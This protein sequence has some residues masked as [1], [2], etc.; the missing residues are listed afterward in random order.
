MESRIFDGSV[1]AV[2]TDGSRSETFSAG[3]RV[4]NVRRIG[5][6]VMFEPVNTYRIAGT[7]AM[8]WSQFETMTTAVREAKVQHLRTK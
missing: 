8:D 1:T 6:R 4:K 7:Y 2:S 5:K 3:E